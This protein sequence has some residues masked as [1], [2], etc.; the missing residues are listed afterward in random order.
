M[1]SIEDRG[2]Q[3]AEALVSAFQRRSSL[4]SAEQK[5]AEQVEIDKLRHERELLVSEREAIHLARL[6][7]RPA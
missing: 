4:R 5:S 1:K 2:R 3:A 7:T 6:Q